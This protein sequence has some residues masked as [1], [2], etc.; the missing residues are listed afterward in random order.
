MCCSEANKTTSDATKSMQVISGVSEPRRH[1]AAVCTSAQLQ[2]HLQSLPPGA[3]TDAWAYLQCRGAKWVPVLSQIPPQSCC[4]FYRLTV[5]AQAS[6]HRCS[7]AWMTASLQLGLTSS[8][9]AFE[10]VSL[11]IPPPATATLND[12]AVFPEAPLL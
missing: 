2:L 3:D 1:P 8:C 6:L 10:G 4:L 7:L 12:T 9:V 11:W 5:G